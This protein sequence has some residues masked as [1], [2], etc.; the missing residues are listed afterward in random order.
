MHRDPIFEFST[1][2]HAGKADFL[3]QCNECGKKFWAIL[4]VGYD[5]DE[6]PLTARKH[7]PNCPGIVVRVKKRK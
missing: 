3:V 7:H 5:L 2:R 1:V 4:D 6:L